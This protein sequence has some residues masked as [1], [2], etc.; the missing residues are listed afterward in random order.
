MGPKLETSGDRRGIREIV[1][2]VEIVVSRVKGG[3]MR[4]IVQMTNF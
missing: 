2:I 3:I 4:M 1:L